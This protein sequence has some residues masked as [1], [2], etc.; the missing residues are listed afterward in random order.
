[1]FIEGYPIINQNYKGQ[2]SFEVNSKQSVQTVTTNLE[3]IQVPIPTDATV[4]LKSSKSIIDAIKDKDPSI[5]IENI[6]IGYTWHNLGDNTQVVEL[7]PEWFVKIDNQWHDT[8]D[9]M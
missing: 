4:S 6:C 3:A 1:M 8:S 9:L 5:K 7:V 2:I